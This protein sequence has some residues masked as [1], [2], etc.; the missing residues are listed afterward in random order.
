MG[1]ARRGRFF[2]KVGSIACGLLWAAVGCA[3][4]HVE[5]EERPRAVLDLPPDPPPDL[6]PDPPLDLPSEPDDPL[7]LCLRVG[8]TTSLEHKPYVGAVGDLTGDGQPDV[9]TLAYTSVGE[10]ALVLLEGRRDGAFVERAPVDSGGSGLELADLDGDGDLDALI[11]DGARAPRYRIGF[12]D[13]AGELRLG[14]FTRIPGRFGGELRHASIVDLDGDGDLDVVAPLW[15]SVRVLENRGDGSF[16]A[17]ARVTVGRD[18]FSTAVAEL[19]GDGRLDLLVTSGA[20]VERRRDVYHSAGAALW[21]VRGGPR[22]WR[23]GEPLALPGA[24]RVVIADLDGD[25]ALEGIATAGD[26]LLIT[27]GLADAA[28]RRLSVTSDGPLLVAEVATAPGLEIITSSYMLSSLGITSAVAG[29]PERESFQA[30]NFVVELFSAEVDG[31]GR[32]PDVLLLNAG[33]PGGA[34]GQPNPGI[35]TLFVDCP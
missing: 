18:P 19:D 20:G 3:P 9:L 12:N 17:G 33:P 21:R 13:G 8:P 2:S 10:L 30:G 16:R 15:D 26:R 11:L 32:A 29:L 35:T 25:G 14:P 24:E 27:R 31:E 5:E 1:T 22:G 23:A 28:P 6:P 4:H 7:G 34:Y